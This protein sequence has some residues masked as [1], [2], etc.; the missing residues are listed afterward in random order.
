MTTWFISDTHFGEQPARRLKLAG[1]TADELDALIINNWRRLL[2]PEDEVWHLGDIGRDWRVLLDLPG[3]K[4]LIVAHAS[5]RR[6][7]IAKSGLFT[8]IQERHQIIADGQ[9]LD[10]IHNPDGCEPGPGATLVHGHHH[11]RL[12]QPG[13]VSVC[14]DHCGWGPVTLGYVLEQM[15]SGGAP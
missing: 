12:P 4:H 1:L 15:R 11:Y 5:D 6:P 7:V 8:T 10:M 14:V 2:S 9:A 13:C 3:R